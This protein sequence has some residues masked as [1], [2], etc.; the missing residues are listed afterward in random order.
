M[1]TLEAA[2]RSGQALW[3]RVEAYYDRT[4]GTFQMQPHVHTWCEVMYVF[5]G[6]CEV[7]HGEEET[8]RMR[9]GD[10]VFLDAGVRHR[11]LTRGDIPCTMLN[12]E[13]SFAPSGDAAFSLGALAGSMPALGALSPVEHG[14]D[15]RGQLFR[16]MDLL[17]Q[18]LSTGGE[19]AGVPHRA[20]ML[21]FL[22]RLAQAV[23]DGR[24]Q[25]GAVGHVRRAVA[26]I[27][28][29]YD[30]RVTLPRLAA[31]LGIHPDHLSHLFRAYMGE[32][33]MR[34]LARVRNDHA[35]TLLL[36]TGMTL[37][38]IAGEVGYASRQQLT[39]SFRQQFGMPPQAYRKRH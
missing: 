33:P 22:V 11:L 39:R 12:L 7:V 35:A 27:Q 10:F 4:W 13:F 32:T 38:S 19:A 17:V 24:Q 3:P 14:G 15:L 34:Y 37:D 36:R 16:A 8:L 20:E 26:H 23:A 31:A 29:H 28:H 1:R 30:E 2:C 21:L 25:P 6:A 18:G 9:A 5:S